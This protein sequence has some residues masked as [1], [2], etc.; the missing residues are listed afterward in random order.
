[1]SDESMLEQRIQET[2]G[3]LWEEAGRPEGQQEQFRLLAQ[4]KI[5]EEENK[6]DEA[7]AESFPASDPVSSGST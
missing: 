3:R 5:K 1:M 6:L 7:L 2:A 4:A